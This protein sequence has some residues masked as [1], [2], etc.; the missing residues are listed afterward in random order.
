MTKIILF[1]AGATAQVLDY[2]LTQA[3]HEVVA[4]TLDQNYIH[5]PS[6]FGRPVVPFETLTQQ[7]SPQHYTLM[8][9]IGYAK[10]N[11]LRAERLQQ[12]REKGYRLFSYISPSATLWQGHPPTTHCKIGEQ[13]LIQPF[14][15]LGENV[16]IGSKC[17][18][19]HHAKIGDHTFM[20]SGVVLGGGVEIGTAAFLGSGAV[21]RNK[22]KIG[23][24]C[25]IGAGAVI[26]EDTPDE[27][28]FLAAPAQQMPLS[29]RD[30]S[31]A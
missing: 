21:V 27:S 15:Q 25:I 9:A 8:I 29:S 26:L 31:P 5:T 3:G 11:Q 12:A 1:G 13:T 7:F 30:L 4:F 24:R 2:H 16:F 20:G 14:A 19:G 17:I 22:A 18:I 28:V 10:V 6:I 23:K